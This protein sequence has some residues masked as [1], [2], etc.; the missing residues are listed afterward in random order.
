MQHIV[1]YKQIGKLALPVIIAQSVILINGMI[2]LA[3]IGSYGT[4]A[5]AAVAIANAICATL[6]NFLEGFRLGTTVLISKAAAA[7]DGPKTMA[8]INAGLFLAATIGILF[9]AFAPYISNTVYVIA[10]NEQMKVHGIAYLKVWLWT[11]PFILFSY[12]LTG[13]F[14]GLRD[15]TTPL[16]STVVI[17]LLNIFF[18]YL[19]VCGGF[20]FPSMGVKGAA[21][22]T[23]LANLAGLMIIINLALKKPFTNK[24]I[25]LKQPFFKLVPEYISLA[26]DVGLNTGFTLLALLLFVW[27]I[28]PLGAA[29]LAVHQIT[30][31]V[32]NF[33]YLPAIGFLITASIIVPQLLENQQ[34]FLL[35]PTVS[36]IGKMSFSVI[37][38]TSSLLFFFA[39]IVSNFFSPADK[40]VAEKAAE[41]LKLVCVGQLFSSI[42]MVLRGALTGCKDTRFIVYEGWV[43]G[44]LIFLPLAYLL[45]IKSGYGVY[46]GY[47][48]FL[49]WCI[50]DCAVL[51]FRFYKNTEKTNVL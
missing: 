27:L 50:T 2:D 3:F 14:R 49:V 41:T 33:A 7:N 38:V 42:Y 31:Q 32:F 35:R 12:V 36:R 9:I 47:V 5:I 23:L 17:C 29:A 46:G 51:V 1:S 28:K 39:S 18:D 22:G 11:I 8:V 40:L 30:L 15:T 34:E 13:L 4:E 26:V 45:A 19:F 43:S 16:Y 10:G 25:H 6:F 37:L 24:Y 48:A 20:G 44:Y 21:W